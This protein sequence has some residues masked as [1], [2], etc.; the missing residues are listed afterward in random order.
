MAIIFENL[1]KAKAEEIKIEDLSTNDAV[2]A[3][4][5]LT[6]LSTVSPK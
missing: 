4:A 1:G 5:Y 2:V 6:I 3:Y